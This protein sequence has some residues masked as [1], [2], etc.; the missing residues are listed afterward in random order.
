MVGERRNQ[1]QRACIVIEA[2]QHERGIG[3]SGIGLVGAHGRR[4]RR[5]VGRAHHGAGND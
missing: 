2:G 1:Q 3:C 5:A 4:Q